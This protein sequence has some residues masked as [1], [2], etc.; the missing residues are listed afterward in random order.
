MILTS[1][2]DFEIK[3]QHESLQH[4]QL[5]HL[6]VFYYPQH[7]THPFLL[8]QSRSAVLDACDAQVVARGTCT[9]LGQPFEHV[10]N[11]NI[12]AEI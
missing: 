5:F 11:S 9:Y 6:Y 7:C 4:D 1:R 3:S 10:S 12:Y 2:S 8:A